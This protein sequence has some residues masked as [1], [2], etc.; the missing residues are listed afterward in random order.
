M[1]EKREEGWNVSCNLLSTH[2]LLV[3][4]PSLPPHRIFHLPPLIYLPPRLYTT[5]LFTLIL[6]LPGFE[7]PTSRSV[8]IRSLHKTTVEFVGER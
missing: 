1:K 6:F 3:F 7:P 2:L 8:A 4:Y 5:Y